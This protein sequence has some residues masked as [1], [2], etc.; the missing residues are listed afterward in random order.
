MRWQRGWR[1]ARRG[2]GLALGARGR[3]ALARDDLERHVEARSLVAGEPDEP[4]P[5]LP[6]RPQR[7]VAAEDE[8]AAESAGRGTRTA[9]Y[10]ARQEK[11]C[12]DA[13]LGRVGRF[14]Q[15]A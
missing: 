2:L 7:A 11:S 1:S 14:L 3:L 8:L 5:P 9:L 13:E 15:A 6:E 12:P 10:F 4:M